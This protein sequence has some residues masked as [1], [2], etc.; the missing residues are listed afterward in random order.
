MG[1]VRYWIRS[2]HGNPAGTLLFSGAVIAA[3]GLMALLS[4]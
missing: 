3:V 2:N 4:R 1:R